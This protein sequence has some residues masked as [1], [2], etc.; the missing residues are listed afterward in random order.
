M[1]LLLDPSGNTP[2]GFY[3][4]LKGY[5]GCTLFFSEKA[6][7][8]N[9]SSCVSY[10]HN[11]AF[12]AN[13]NYYCLLLLSREVSKRA[14]TRENPDALAP[15]NHM[16]LLCK[17]HRALGTNCLTVCVGRTA[18]GPIWFLASQCA[19]SSWTFPLA[20]LLLLSL[21]CTSFLSPF[22]LPVT[23][24]TSVVSMRATSES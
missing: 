19:K 20:S 2:W 7:L 16:Y 24:M 3:G 5:P 4:G 18:S 12:S 22:S 6:G 1:G 17:A 10:S 11:R 15:T 23:S 21:G 14:H 8:K 13:N 9:L